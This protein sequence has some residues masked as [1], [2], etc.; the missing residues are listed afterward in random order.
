VFGLHVTF[1]YGHD[2]AGRVVS[3]RVL[4]GYGVERMRYV[5]T[6]DGSRDERVGAWGGPARY[7]DEDDTFV[8][9]HNERDARGR[10]TRARY[11]DASGGPRTSTGEA[12]EARFSGHGESF[13]PT[14]TT[15]F[16]R[17][18][19]PTDD[20]GGV[21][22]LVSRLSPWGYADIRFFAIDA[23]AAQ[24]WP[25]GRRHRGPPSAGG[26]SRLAAA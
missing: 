14:V 13:L 16:D 26:M 2:A 6:P 15:R 22:R 11:E 8:V 21:H 9:V 24:Q 12:T 23:T 20:N 5:Y 4:D 18:G 1:L 3:E 25:I 17:Q 7:G 19:R 10:R